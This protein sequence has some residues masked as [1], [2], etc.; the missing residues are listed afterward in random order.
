MWKSTVAGEF[1]DNLRVNNMLKS[2]EAVIHIIH[3]EKW[4]ASLSTF[5]PQDNSFRFHKVIHALI[6]HKGVEEFRPSG[7]G[8]SVHSICH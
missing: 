1:I 7:C 6:V 4:T 8:P 2:R 5:C 3:G